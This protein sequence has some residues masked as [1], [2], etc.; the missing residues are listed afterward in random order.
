VPQAVQQGPSVPL[1]VPVSVGERL[2]DC[3]SVNISACGLALS[4]SLV[5][6]A[7]PAPRDVLPASLILPARTALEIDARLHV[8]WVQTR[9]ARP[10]VLFGGSFAGLGAAARAQIE[11]YVADYRPRVAVIGAR[12]DQ[13][14]ALAGRLG[15]LALVPVG[16]HDDF[17]ELGTQPPFSVIVIT[18]DDDQALTALETVAAGYV[19]VVEGLNALHYATLTPRVI[20]CG[21]ASADRLLALHNAARL[22]RSVAAQDLAGL[23]AAV[24]AGVEDFALRSELQQRARPLATRPAETSPALASLVYHGEP[25]QSVVE[26]VRRAA[27][28]PV[29]VLLRGETGAGKEILARALHELSQRGQGRGRFVAQD[30]AALTET[31]LDSELFGHVRGAFT[32]AASHHLGL[33]G[34]ADGGT[35]FLDEIENTTP[36]L[37][38]K[39]LRVLETGEVRPVGAARARMVD[40]R[41]IAASNRDLLP[42]VRAGRFRADLYYR[43]ER[44]V[45]DVPPLRARPA[46]ILPLARDFATR[47]AGDLG[48]PAPVFDPAFERRLLAHDW[49]GNVR[50]LRN[51]VERAVVGGGSS[52]A[53]LAGPVSRGPSGNGLRDR[54]AEVERTIIADALAEHAGVVRAAARALGMDPVTLARRARRLGIRIQRAGGE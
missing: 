40:V 37:Q 12:P 17:Y 5:G 32:G 26:L 33:F 30:C 46:D 23:A 53:V 50:E 7:A 42:E 28:L 49:P 18:G 38:A 6:G 24:R 15:D 34:A 51:A 36:A 19:D 31:L 13:L 27:R 22:F 44:L 20:F 4:A 48:V 35:L 14:A 47:I 29:A 39:L 8:E 9:G 41:V 1:Y 3:F 45:I 11:R 25:M 54:L 10:S 2:Y 52:G 21:R 43:L 16:D